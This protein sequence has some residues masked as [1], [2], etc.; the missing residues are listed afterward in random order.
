MLKYITAARY[1]GNWRGTAYAFVLHWKEQVTQYEK[2]ELEAIPPKQKLRMLQNTVGDVNDLANVKQL[3]DQVVARGEVP[4]GF[5]GYVELLLS[6][7]S[8]Y[9]KNHD[10]PRQ[11]GPRKVYAAALESDDEAYYDAHQTELYTLGTDVSEI[12]A[13]ASNTFQGW[14]QPNRNNSSFIPREEWLKLSQ[15]QRDELIAKRRKERGAQGGTDSSNRNQHRQVHVHDIQDDV[16][17]D[18]IIEYTVNVHSIH[19]TFADSEPSSNSLL[20]HMAG[21]TNPGPCPGDIRQV[22]AAHQRPNVKIPPIKVNTASTVPDTFTVGDTTYYLNKGETISIQ[23]RQYSAHSTIFHY[24]V[25]KHAS[26]MGDKALVDRG[27]N[28]GI[29]GA[30]MCVVESCERFV[31]VSG[32]AGHRENKLRIVTAQTVI[33]THK[34]PVVAVFHQ[35][36]LLGKGKSILSCVQMEHF[37]SDIN[38]KSL[39]LPIDK[40]RILI[41][42]YQIPLDSHNCLPYLQCR[43]PMQAD[44]DML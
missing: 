38:N 11:A 21:Q 43:S 16:N 37:D 5:E 27:A 12:Y 35:M 4:L 10:T 33:N 24:S 6:A 14:S 25:G 22:L 28:G 15:E 31:D 9:D 36:A 1:P 20:A 39:C 17:L 34:G 32:L 3:N 44:L 8:T 19:D 40:Q 29:C 41:D 26:T 42:G 30:D 18:D 13:N 2:L 7:C 23:G